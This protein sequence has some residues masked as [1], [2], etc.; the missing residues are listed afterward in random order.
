MITGCDSSSRGGLVHV[1]GT[2][3]NCNLFGIAWD[4]LGWAVVGVCGA[5]DGCVY[6]C[7]LQMQTLSDGGI[8]DPSITETSTHPPN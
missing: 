7:A 8:P 6:V 4:N 3:W 1:T 2:G 5:H